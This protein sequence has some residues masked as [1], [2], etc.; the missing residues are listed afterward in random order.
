MN[1]TNE[2]TIQTTEKYF[3]LQKL[4]NILPL[5]MHKYNILLKSVQLK[6]N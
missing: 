2:L 6:S 1:P 3:Y 4:N 5:T